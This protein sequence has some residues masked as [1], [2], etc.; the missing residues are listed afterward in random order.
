MV[1][2]LPLNCT[3]VRSAYFKSAEELGRK[4]YCGYYQARCD[5]T[6]GSQQLPAAYDWR[7][8][9]GA[10]FEPDIYYNDTYGLPN[11]ASPT[12]YQRV[13]A[14][15]NAAV[16][17]WLRTFVGADASATLVGVQE[18]PKGASEIR[19]DFSSLLGPLFFTWVVQMLLPIFLM[20]LVYEKEKRLRMMMKMHGLG[21]GAYW[22][23]TYTWFYALYALY[24]AIFMAFGSLIRLNM[25]IKN[26]FGVQ[27]LLFAI[28]GHNMI[29]FAF[30]LS[31]FFTSAKTGTV[32]AYLVVFGTG[33]I[34]SLLLSRL[35]STG[36][37]YVTALEVVPSFALFRG[38]YEL[39]EYSFIGVYRGSAGMTWAD[40]ADPRN[41]MGKVF[42]ILAAEWW[43]F[44]ALAWYLEQVF[45]SGTGNRRHPLF[46]LDRWRKGSK[47]AATAKLNA[48]ATSEALEQASDVAAEHERVSGLTDYE[49]HPIV[50]RELRKV[51]PGQDGQPPKLAVRQLNLAIEKGE[52]FG[53]LGPNGAG[54]STSINMMVGLLE[55]THGSALIGGYDIRSDLGA[56]YSLMGVCP[57]HD[58]LWE[59]LTGREHLLFYGRLKGLTGPSL[60]EAVESGLRA[61]NLWN[62]G[63]ADKQAAQYSG[64]MKRRLSVAISFMGNPLVVYLDEP[65]TGLDPASRRNLWDVVKAN[66]AG[67]GMVLTT[68]SMEEAEMLCDRL[69]IFVDGRLV[70]I[71]NP[72]EITSR[73]GGYLV[74]TLTVAAGQESAARAFVERLS[75]GARLTYSVGGTLKFELPSSEVTLSGVF[76]AMA[77][78]KAGSGPGHLQVLDWGVANASLEEVFIKFA[79]QIGAKAGD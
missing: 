29:A 60:Q 38:L 51:Y 41:G 14:I 62:G 26:S 11:S 19:L 35:F 3:D 68:H 59:T 9:D 43:G 79:R 66:K 10:R 21:D 13:P 76:S 61:V 37:W 47:A 55:P 5:G 20:Q 16:N 73:Y 33:L 48:A 25:F 42:I 69:G 22:L 23:V 28:F 56:I 34:G 52:C 67:R 77:A 27:I 57:Q 46:F 12:S 32:F 4:L 18:T 54:K 15:I 6:I 45:A 63:V 39:G 50:V 65:S 2:G 49:S 8:T 40:L 7:A 53:L 78:A 75:P 74:M 36:L 30:L 58:L 72:K 70:C 1:T 17:A 24:I 31:C 71:G 44:M 64:G